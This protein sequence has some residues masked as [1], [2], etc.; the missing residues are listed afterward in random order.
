MSRVLKRVCLALVAMLVLFPIAAE[1]SVFIGDGDIGGIRLFDSQGTR[2]ESTAEVASNIGQGWIIHN[3]DTPILI[4]TPK[5]SINLYEDSILITGDLIS[6]NPSLYLVKGKATFTTYDMEGG[7]LSVATPVSLFKLTGDGE[8]FVITDDNEE[9]V[10]SF[11]GEVTSFNSITKATKHIASFQKLLMQESLATAKQIP[12]G[13]YLTYATYPDLMLAKQLISEMAKPVIAPTPRAPKVSSVLLR[14]AK[15]STPATPGVII[16]PSTAP[17]FT[18]VEE[19]M[20]TLPPEPSYLSVRTEPVKVPQAPTTLT[21][22]WIPKPKA[23]IVVTVRPMA[24][25]MPTTPTS[26]VVAT[27]ELAIQEEP[28]LLPEATPSVY[29]E[30][31]VTIDRAEV[32]VQEQVVESAPIAIEEPVTVE[33]E[34]MATQ[35]QAPTVAE[36]KIPLK[37]KPQGIL[38]TVEQK[39]KPGSFGLE[40]AYSFVFD[41]TDNDSMSHALS[42]KPYFTYKNVSLILQA[43]V[44]TEDF[45]TYSSNVTDIPTGTLPLISYGFGFI[46]TLR[47]GYSSSP[48]FLALDKSH[49]QS[50]LLDLF[51][52]PAFGESNKLSLYNKIE[53]GDFSSTIYFDDLYLT[54]L[55]ANKSQY[56]SFALTYAKSEGY[57]FA[58]SL[59]AL[60]KI[61]PSWTVDLYPNIN[62]LFPI[63]DVRTTQL[64]ALVMASGYLPTYPTVDFSQFVDATLSSFFPNYLLSGGLSLKQGP[65][66]AKILASISDGENRNLLISDLSYA[67]D[68]S[69][70]S[71]FDILAQ[72]TYE[73]EHFKAD[74][75]LNLPFDNNLRIVTGNLP[76]KADFS[77]LTLSYKQKGVTISLGL[78]EMGVSETLTGILDGSKA[79]TT[80]FGGQTA[81]SFLS[82]AYSTGDLTL[83]VKAD[84]PPDTTVYT[85][86]R[87]TVSALYKVGM[88]F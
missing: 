22:T 43:S 40:A 21:S 79:I 37:E 74:L 82:V 1:D 12:A 7:T 64:N 88:Q 9:S 83:K 5:G 31:Q 72:A 65:F 25:Q 44:T 42:L 69:Y 16:M 47:I 41:G 17:T 48:F 45:S 70:S 24:P 23:R 15:P 8:M 59:G 56:G 58:F 33:S 13:Y 51:Y 39:T 68:T 66:F 73:G 76:Y 87:V 36:E 81:T 29:E 19:K 26:K 49:H 27:A 18:S 30:P 84:Y 46:D 34:T 32:A 67:F 60:A 35:E 63:I 52:A 62:F 38:S 85:T 11:S 4:I 86:P 14:P 57:R 54:R 50:S 6:R 77:Q 61:T 78:Q 75:L 28:T 55:L 10:T 20:L 71:S 53:V 3:P 80:L 2:L